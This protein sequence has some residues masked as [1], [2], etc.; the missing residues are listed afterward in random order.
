M[1]AED[2]DRSKKVFIS[3]RQASDDVMFGDCSG[4][5]SGATSP[6]SRISY[7]ESPESWRAVK[8]FAELV[9]LLLLTDKNSESTS[10]KD[11]DQLAA[12]YCIEILGHHRLR[13]LMSSDS[14]QLPQLYSCTTSIDALFDSQRTKKKLSRT[15]FREIAKVSYKIPERET[16]E[17]D[18]EST[19]SST[20]SS[21]EL[22]I[23]K[24]PS[25]NRQRS[26]SSVAAL[27]SYISGD[28]VN[29]GDRNKQIETKGS[30]V[31]IDETDA[32]IE[33]KLANLYELEE[34]SRNSLAELAKA[35]SES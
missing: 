11:I 15:L 29:I 27:L 18:N 4:L 2:K 20:I 25:Q 24:E 26:K 28:R 5:Y 16:V 14:C 6:M 1:M 13:E 30:H 35:V 17:V 32:R 34:E 21:V 22:N 9:K 23:N 8:G 10:I 31:E 3:Y 33:K 7:T 12:V 19:A